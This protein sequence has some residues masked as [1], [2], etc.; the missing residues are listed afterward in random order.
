[1]NFRHITLKAYFLN[2][3]IDYLANPRVRD[4]GKYNFIASKQ[5]NGAGLLIELQG[6][7]I[8]PETFKHRKPVK[9]HIAL[10]TFKIRQIMRQAKD[11]EAQKEKEL[12][13]KNTPVKALWK[14][15]KFKDVPSK[16][17]EILQV[18]SYF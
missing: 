8:V 5:G 14:S 18:F 12:A 10:N 15:E 6:R 3:K 11:K 13:E 1:M 7:T 2:R 9:N 17:L 16:I 4:S